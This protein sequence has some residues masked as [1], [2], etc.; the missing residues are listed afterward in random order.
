MVANQP[1]NPSSSSF[2]YLQ[3]IL[4]SSTTFIFV[5]PSELAIDGGGSNNDCHCWPSAKKNKNQ[6]LIMMMMMYAQTS[7]NHG[8]FF[9]L[10]L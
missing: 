2:H 3:W 10:L 5:C 6:K 7:S 4:K 8:G 9:I 1:T